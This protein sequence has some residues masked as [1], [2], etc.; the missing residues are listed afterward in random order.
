MYFEYKKSPLYMI[1]KELNIETE[2]EQKW[3]YKAS[4][5][6]LTFYEMS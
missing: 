4:L 6:D 1:T 2:K 3:P 5:E